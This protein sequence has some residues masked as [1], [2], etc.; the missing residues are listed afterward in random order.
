MFGFEMAMANAIQAV[1]QAH[2]DSYENKLIMEAPIEYQGA[3]M[4]ARDARKEKERLERRERD[5]H[6]QLCR[7]IEKAGE[8]ARPRGWEF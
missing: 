6:D 2:Q 5:M 8:N 4:R 1:A 7:S 3:M